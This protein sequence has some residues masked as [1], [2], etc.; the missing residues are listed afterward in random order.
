MIA[1]IDSM[2]ISVSPTPQ[3]TNTNNLDV[4]DTGV[5]N[6]NSCDVKRVTQYC[7][8]GKFQNILIEGNGGTNFCFTTLSSNA[9]YTAKGECDIPLDMHNKNSSTSSS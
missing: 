3:P 9:K 4:N 8:P 2:I 1:D 6:F 5:I 7:S